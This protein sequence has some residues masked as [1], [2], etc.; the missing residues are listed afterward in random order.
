[1]TAIN[2]KNGVSGDWS[3]NANWNPA[4]VPG[5]GDAVTIAAASAAAY[6]VSISVAEAAGTLT[7]NQKNAT[8]AD[9]ATLKTESM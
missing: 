4:N 5:A 8:I 2:W 3:L 9:Q 1:M 7:L 6:T